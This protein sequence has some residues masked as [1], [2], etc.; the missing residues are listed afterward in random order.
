MNGKQKASAIGGFIALGL[1]PSFVD[2]EQSP[3]KRWQIVA[4]YGGG[5]AMLYYGL[6]SKGRR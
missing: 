4:F 3:E 6:L 1:S 2:W 5:I